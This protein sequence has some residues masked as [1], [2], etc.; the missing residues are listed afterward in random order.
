MIRTFAHTLL[1]LMLIYS[2]L[3]IFPA[4]AGESG[5]TFRDCPTCPEMVVIPAGNFIMGAHNGDA[6]EYPIHRVTVENS[7]ALGKTEITQTQWRAIMRDQTRSIEGNDPSYFSSCGDDCPVEQVSWNDVQIFVQKLSAKTRKDYRLPSEAEWEY[8]C[9]AGE[10][11]QYCGSDNVDSVAWYIASE[12][13]ENNKGKATAHVAAKEP[14][15]F[16]LYDMSGNVWEWVADSYHDNYKGA[17]TDTRPWQS[18]GKKRVLRGGSWFNQPLS[19]RA[20]SRYKEVP[21]FRSKFAGFRVVRS[22]P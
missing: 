2:A 14:N 6:D 4:H 18:D 1:S 15:A 16:G 19:L 20:A 17:P 5:Y 13:T 8:A 22:L 3:I 21:T 10:Q 9:R 7:F 11:L 12:G